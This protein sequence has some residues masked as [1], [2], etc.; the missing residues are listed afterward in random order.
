MQFLVKLYLDDCNLLHKK[1]VAKIE[2]EDR[3]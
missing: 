3:Y 2:I 1:I